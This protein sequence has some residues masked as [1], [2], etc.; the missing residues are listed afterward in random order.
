VLPLHVVAFLVCVSVCVCAY[1]Y[2]F[3][4]F[5]EEVGRCAAC[6]SGF[7]WKSMPI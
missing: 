7:V 3:K 5:I 4:S 6:T 2:V 1:M